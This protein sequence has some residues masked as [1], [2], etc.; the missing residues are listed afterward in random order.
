MVLVPLYLNEIAPKHLRGAFGVTCQVFVVIG[1]VIAQFLGLFLS[2]IPYWRLILLFGGVIGATHFVLLLFACE[3]PKWVALQHGGQSRASAILRHIRGE[4]SEHEVREWRRH[5]LL[6]TESDG[7]QI[8]RA[9]LTVDAEEGLL[10][11]TSATDIIHSSSSPAKEMHTKLTILQFLRSP[12]Y[13]PMIRAILIV[14]LAQQLSG[15]NAVIFYSTSILSTILPSSSAVI[16]L[17]IS[18][19]NL[20]TTLPSTT[21]IERSGR[22]PL[23]LW[24]ISSM[25][26]ASLFLGLGIVYSWRLICVI[27]SFAFVAAFSIGLGPIPFLIISEFVDAEGVSAGQSFG[28]VT[29]WIATFCVVFPQHF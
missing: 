16:S 22:K 21:L 4:D 1:I 20:C 9:L 7:N 19:I 12:A 6:P 13:Q 18:L 24:S 27:A 23:L 29:N 28:L 2:S 3:S 5:S 10:R 11:S 17:I 26:V 14:M 8:L 15:I 25:G